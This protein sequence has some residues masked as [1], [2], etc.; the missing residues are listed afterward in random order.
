MAL[1]PWEVL[2]VVVSS[3]A[4]LAFGVAAGV[5]LSYLLGVA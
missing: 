4:A 5:W 2:V 1:S 3:V